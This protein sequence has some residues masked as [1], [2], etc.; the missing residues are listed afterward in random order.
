[1]PQHPNQIA[2]RFRPGQSGN[3]S[4]RPKGI[5][6]QAREHTADALRVLVDGLGD[7]DPRVRVAAAKE[8]LDRGYGKP[9]AMT[10]DVTNKLDDLD[11]VAL[12]AAISALEGHLQSLGTDEGGEG[13]P[14][15]PN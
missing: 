1:M 8:I 5:G 14:G 3:P 15:L 4:G 2:S 13:A 12:D 11:D 10:A 7:E 6:A 9:V